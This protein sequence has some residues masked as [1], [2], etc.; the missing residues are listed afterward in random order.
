MIGLIQQKIQV[1]GLMIRK[2]DME[3]RIA[4]LEQEIQLLKSAA[5]IPY[6]TEQAFRTRLSDLT[7]ELPDGFDDAPLASI[8]E[9]SGGITVDTEARSAINTIITRLEDLGLIQPN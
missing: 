7:P 3:E 1:L 2:I 5:A 8:T 4:Q 9:P 6:E